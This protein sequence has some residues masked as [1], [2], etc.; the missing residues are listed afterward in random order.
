MVPPRLVMKKPIPQPRKTQTI[1]ETQVFGAVKVCREGGHQGEPAA[2]LPV[3]DADDHEQQHD[4]LL[5]DHVGQNEHATGGDGT[6]ETVG[7]HAPDFIR[8][9]TGTNPARCIDQPAKGDQDPGVGGQ[10]GDIGSGLF[11]Q[12]GGIGD[13]QKPGLGG[14]GE[15]DHQGVEL[16]G[17]ENLFGGPVVLGGVL[18]G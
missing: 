5:G 10:E 15:H 2:I 14:D 13:D 9:K 6:V 3:S 4:V 12:T 18:I 1:V 16:P 11:Q 8:V 7:V 17:F